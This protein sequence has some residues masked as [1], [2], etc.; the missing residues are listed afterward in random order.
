VAASF[1]YFGLQVTFFGHIAPKKSA[2]KSC[3]SV[4]HF[5]RL[6]YGHRVIHTQTSA[7]PLYFR[8]KQIYIQPSAGAVFMK[9]LEAA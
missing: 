1:H 7:P 8:R 4:F 9:V 3:P 6:H 2:H 5:G